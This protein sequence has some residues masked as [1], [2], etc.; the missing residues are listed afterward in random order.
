MCG[1]G[2]QIHVVGLTSLGGAAQVPY[3]LCQL[4]LLL[5][6]EVFQ[7]RPGLGV[8]GAC[9]MRSTLSRQ[10]IDAVSTVMGLVQ[11]EPARCAACLTGQDLKHFGTH[12]MSSQQDNEHCGT[13]DMPHRQQVK[14]C[15]I[16][17][18]HSS[19]ALAPPQLPQC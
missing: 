10:E 8:G 11:V 14:H 2:Q 5:R 1:D 19:T 18:R 4:P 17:A 9:E 6:R 15:G 3:C 12:G 13:R 7:C 16:R